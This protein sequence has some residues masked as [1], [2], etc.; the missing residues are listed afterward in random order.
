MIAILRKSVGGGKHED[1]VNLSRYLETHKVSRL[2]IY[3]FVRCFANLSSRT[4]GGLNSVIRPFTSSRSG[5]EKFAKIPCVKGNPRK[6][7]YHDS[8]CSFPI[9]ERVHP[10][11]RRE[12][13][14]ISR[15]FLAY[16]FACISSMQKAGN[17]ALLLACN[18]LLGGIHLLEWAHALI[19]NGFL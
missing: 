18:G 11:E 7:V 17:P 14:R 13:F 15:A 3:L 9:Y 6:G 4:L 12:L 16:G 10:Y 8:R 19:L 1:I 5:I 2:F